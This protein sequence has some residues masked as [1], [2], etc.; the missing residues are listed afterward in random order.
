MP[1]FL[2]PLNQEITITHIECD[3]KEINHLAALGITK[4]AKVTLLSS[5]NRSVIVLVRGSRLA[6]DRNLASKIF[7]A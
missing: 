1:I 4:D 2:A 3:D 5:Q 6:L 7:V